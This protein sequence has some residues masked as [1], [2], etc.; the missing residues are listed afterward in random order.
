MS[1]RRHL[2]S[3]TRK[4]QKTPQKSKIS[5]A[6]KES[7]SKRAQPEATEELYEVDQILGAEV[8]DN[9]TYYKIKWKGYD[10]L[11]VVCFKYI[12]FR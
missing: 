11:V 9:V 12:I 8:K 7:P 2:K 10:L 6:I 1:P 5:K 4:Q 3:P